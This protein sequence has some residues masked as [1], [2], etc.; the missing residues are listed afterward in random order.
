MIRIAIAYGG[1]SV[2]HEVSVLTALEAYAAIDTERFDPILVYVDLQGRWWSG[3]GLSQPNFYRAFSR[4][5]LDTRGVEQISMLP[6]PSNK[7]LFGQRSPRTL[8]FKRP[9][10]PQEIDVD[11]WM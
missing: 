7:R 6:Q 11:I 4:G 2:E 5:V 9:R 10:K 3:E 8:R 1:R